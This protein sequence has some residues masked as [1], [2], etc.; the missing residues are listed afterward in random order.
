MADQLLSG[1]KVVECGIWFPLYLGKLLADFGAGWIK[2]EE[3]V[4]TTHGSGRFPATR[5]IP[6]KRSLSQHQ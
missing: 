4:E 6:R 1:I 5:H 3:P 2:V